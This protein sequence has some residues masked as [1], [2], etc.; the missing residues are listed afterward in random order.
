M[1]RRISSRISTRSIRQV[2]SIHLSQAINEKLTFRRITIISSSF[3]AFSGSCSSSVDFKE[4][5]YWKSE[6][7]RVSNRPCADLKMRCS[8]TYIVIPMNQSSGHKKPH[9]QRAFAK[10]FG[11]SLLV[12]EYVGSSSLIIGDMVGEDRLMSYRGD[13]CADCWSW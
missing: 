1:P 6:M 10:V 4:S 13:S 12:F 7:W 9:F 5:T 3:W 8:L 2:S 11:S